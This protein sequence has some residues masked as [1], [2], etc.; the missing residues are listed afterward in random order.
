[1]NHQNQTNMFTFLRTSLAVVLCILGTSA[2]LAQPTEILNEELRDG[3]L[4]D[5]WSA[6]DVN[7]S[8][9]AGGRADL[10]A[11]TGVLTTPV[12]DLSEFDSV[13]LIFDVAKLGTGDN[14]P[15]TVEVS[16]DGGATFTAQS[17]DS[18]VPTS[19]TYLTSGPTSINTL[20]D[21]MVIRFTAANS[22]S[23]KRL[24]D[25]LLIGNPEE[26]GG[27]PGEPEVDLHVLADGD[28]MLNA[29]A[30]DEAAGTYPQ[31]MLFYFSTD[32]GLQSYSPTNNGTEVYD[33][34]YNVTARC[35]LSGLGEDGFSFFNTGSAQYANCAS[36]DAPVT[37]FLGSAILGLDLSNVDYARAE[38][39]A[40]TINRNE[41]D[42][43][44]QL[45]YR[46]GNQ[47]GYI[48]F[49]ESTLYSVV[50]TED[51]DS[52]S[53]WFEL[54]EMLLGQEE[55]YLRWVYYQLPGSPGGGRPEIA[56]DDILITT[57]L[58]VPGCN[59]PNACNFDEDATQDDGSCEYLSCCEAEAGSLAPGETSC[60]Q[61][62]G[63]AT[64]VVVDV[65][66]IPE[67][68][69]VA[70]VL[71]EG[72]ELVIIDLAGEPVFSGLTAG[73]YTIHTFVYPEGLDLSVVEFGQTTGFDVNALL[74]QGGGTICAALD[75]AGAPI[76]IENCPVVEGCTDE[77]ACN[78]DPIANEDDG[79]CE[80]LSCCEAEAFELSIVST[81]CAD[82]DGGSVTFETDIASITLP[83]GYTTGVVLTQGAELVIL[84]FATTETVFSSLDAGN[85]TLHALTY[86]EGLDLSFIE[87]G[88]TTGVEVNS[89]L[90]QGG[91]T[92]CAALDVSG[93]TFEIETCVVEGCT[94]M[95]ACNY[96]PNA[97]TDDGSCVFVGDACD[98][99][100]PDTINDVIDENC[101]CVG[102]PVGIDEHF[103]AS[104]RVYPNPVAHELMIDFG[105][106]FAPVMVTLSDLTGRMVMSTQVIGRSTLSVDHLAVGTYILLFESKA[107]S[108]TVKVQVSR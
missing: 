20:G 22:P 58:P 13:V 78:F 102:E 23:D 10:A 81:N 84:G 51:G 46:I 101:D 7:F 9:A 28:Y 107:S 68:Y 92:L 104:L 83:E 14:G 98:D 48:S 105:D 50:G 64:A 43:G 21:N 32:P 30:G 47:G 38:W 57:A 70:Y 12:L 89:L 35:R 80:Y 6:V 61:E 97:T 77:Q 85:Y 93:T 54:P 40:R 25:V 39:V 2:L 72:A 94:S 65:P 34:G 15:I 37:R 42:Y 31:S 56:V 100:D 82:N 95:E 29:W 36:G 8:L 19:S 108:G 90:A 76:T 17:F 60:A 52:E 55:V 11:L 26:N 71:T 44:I 5:G 74:A 3:D 79:S 91:G 96:D 103:M 87:F 16:D 1:M 53:F 62:G 73:E 86:P 63:D 67:G 33:C 106:H 49:D 75:V 88:V 18:P 66:F 4:P 24:R 69:L 59:D 27:E 99:G 41:R 45:Q